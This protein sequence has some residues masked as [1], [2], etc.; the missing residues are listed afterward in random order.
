MAGRQSL[1]GQALARRRPHYH[2]PMSLFAQLDYLYMP[3]RDTAADLRF[4][5]DV[6]GAKPVFTVDGMGARVAMLEL[7][8]FRA[9]ELAGARTAPDRWFWG[10]Y[11]PVLARRSVRQRLD[12]LDAYVSTFLER[13]LPS[14]GIAL[15]AN[16]LR[17]LWTMLTHVHGNLL[18]TI[19]SGV[20]LQRVSPAWSYAIVFGFTL[21]VTTLALAGGARALFAK[22]MA[23]LAFAIYIAIAFRIFEQTH[24]VL[25]L[26]APLGAALSTALWTALHANYSAVGIAEV[27]VIGV[28]FSWLIWRTG[29][30]RV[31][32]FCHALY[33]SL[34]VVALRYVPLPT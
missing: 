34:I 24:W 29:S 28:F 19:V 13:D 20:Y 12:W 3:S 2:G 10:G 8:P 32:I 4:Y 7:T 27:F 1:T 18:K 15:P 9:A 21:V 11:P 23:V 5:V 33:N 25:P 16:R 14:L 17:T 26:M 30:L 22:I 31:A 6:L